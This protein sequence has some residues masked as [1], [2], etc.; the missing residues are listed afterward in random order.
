MGRDELQ[1]KL[2]KQGWPD[3]LVAQ[4]LDTEFRSFE[5]SL[6]VDNISK[7][8]GLNQVLQRITFKVKAGEIFGICG[9]SGCGK[10][11][12]LNILVGFLPQD[13]GQ[14]WLSQNGEQIPLHK[15]F[16]GLSTQNPSIYGRLTVLE[17]LLHFAS[18]YN[19][20]PA[21]ARREAERL[22]ELVGLGSHR[23]VLA[24]HLS[25]GQQKRLDIACALINNPRILVLDEPTSGL[26]E[27]IRRQLW[28]LIQK[29]NKKGT[30][31]L[32][33]S[34]SIAEMASVCSTL[35]VISRGVATLV[36]PHSAHVVTLET[37]KKEYDLLKRFDGKIRS[38]QYVIVTKTP[39][40]TIAALAKQLEDEDIVQLSVTPYAGDP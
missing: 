12:L 22:I 26:D 38:G 23:E 32:V 34:H 37:H 5:G 16:F 31:V 40:A 33:A 27:H 29:I 20:S 7:S 9:A 28:M 4:Y 14:V 39:V 30:T 19:L 13:N 15:T 25:G 36:D 1:A 21:D 8:F 11:T 17:N 24:N 2:L 10:T 3:D 18:L 35:C 6:V